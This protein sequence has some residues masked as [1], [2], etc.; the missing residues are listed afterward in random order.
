MDKVALEN[1]GCFDELVIDDWFHLEQT[2]TRRYWIGV[3]DAHINIYIPTKGPVAVHVLRGE[4]GSPLCGTTTTH[5]QRF[6]EQ[7]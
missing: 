5:G 6:E 3:G 2:S 4:T 1:D 7:P